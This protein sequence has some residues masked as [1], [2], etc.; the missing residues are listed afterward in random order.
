MDMGLL[1]LLNKIEQRKQLYMEGI[2]VSI[3][4]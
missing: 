1:K 4:N 3:F 2:D